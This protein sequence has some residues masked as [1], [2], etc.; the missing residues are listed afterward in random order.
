[1]Q[2]QAVGSDHQ[3][4]EWQF[5]A[6]DVRP[7]GRW[8]EGRSHWEGPAVAGLKIRELT[9]TYYETGDWRLYRAGYALRV[10]RGENSTEDGFEAT[11]KSLAAGEDDAD[12]LRRRREIS[13]EVEGAGPEALGEAAGRIGDYLRA[14]V[15][16]EDLRQI[17]TVKTRR[18]AYTLSLQG[19][20]VG[21]VALDETEILLDNEE[22][23]VQLRRIE[24]EVDPE[25]L[26]SLEHFVERLRAD[27]KLSP[28]TAS[29]YQAALFARGLTPPGPLDLGPKT[30]DDS[31]TVGEVAFA[32]MRE[33]F[34]LFLAHEPG[35][36]L[37]EDTEKLHDM[38]VASRRLRAAMKIFKD[39][40]PVRFGKVQDEL[41]H[42]DRALGE[43]RDVDVQL[44]QLDVW[45]DE[46]EPED[47]E[48]LE[49]LRDVLKEQRGKARKAMLRTLDS[50][51]Y[52]RFV[53]SLT[54]LLERGPSHR[55]RAAQRPVLDVAPDLIHH[56]YRKVRKAGDRITRE[57]PGEGYHDLRKKGK[58]LRYALEFLSGVYG[59]PA[60]KLI[61]SLKDLQD[62]LGDHQDT[63][64][65][66]S[67]LRDA[68]IGRHRGRKL[69]PETIFVMGGIA[70]RYEAWGRELRD[71]FPKAYRKIKGK[72]WK[73]LKKVLDDRR[74]GDASKK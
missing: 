49:E 41:R 42:F 34:E 1:M 56:R 39:A 2:E 48:S 50:R 37:G 28:A 52:A 3:E 65:A 72:G 11:M 64:V 74:P 61:S 54:A 14:L 15:G 31:L 40:L 46:A 63:V 36:R 10:R 71:N 35:T 6:L 73:K 32:V 29:K 59:K 38:R 57:S 13:G 26:S 5:D 16:P 19:A 47:R 18:S 69:S 68:G 30:V 17:F 62:V 27:C 33:Q 53:E 24:V 58:R 60:G 22:E 25:A 51:R 23:P 44:Q 7:V 70:Y 55:S 12:G 45:T 43:V 8:L 20:Q 66:V 4:V 21:E 67:H 9:D